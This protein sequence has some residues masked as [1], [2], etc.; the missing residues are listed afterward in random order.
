MIVSIR[1]KALRRFF[2]Q[3]NSRGLKT[4][5]L[6]RL[7]KMLSALDVA[8]DVDELGTIP[9]WRLHKLSGELADYWSLS[10]TGN[11]RLIFLFADGE[12]SQVDLVDYH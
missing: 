9:G 12:V 5:L 2:E 8:V 4:D 1:H 10:V 6:D 11:W 3:G 7:E